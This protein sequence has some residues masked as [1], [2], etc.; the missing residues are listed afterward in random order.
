[1]NIYN[2]NEKNTDTNYNKKDR[3]FLQRMKNFFFAEGGQIENND[4]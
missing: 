1:M 4:E 2:N 3:S